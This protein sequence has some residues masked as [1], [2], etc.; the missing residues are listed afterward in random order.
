MFH[1]VILNNTFKFYKTFGKFQPYFFQPTLDFRGR[2][3]TGFNCTSNSSFPLHHADLQ[4]K[5]IYFERL[6]E[7]SSSLN[8]FDL[9][10]DDFQFS[11]LVMFCYH[12]S[13]YFFQRSYLFRA[14]RKKDFNFVKD[15]FMHFC[16]YK[17]S[18]LSPLLFSPS[19][20]MDRAFEQCIFD[21]RPFSLV[22]HLCPSFNKTFIESYKNHFLLKNL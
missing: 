16:Y 6:T 7:I 13:V 18:K 17:P 14:C 20:M 22:P 3:V 8:C 9:P 19:M 2:R 10:I 12:F 1:G 11:A 15:H 4:N 21:N 5:I